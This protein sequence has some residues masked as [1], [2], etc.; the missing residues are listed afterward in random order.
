M[1]QEADW[2]TKTQEVS[3][4]VM[5]DLLRAVRSPRLPRTRVWRDLG[6]W[7]R[8]PQQVQARFVPLIGPRVHRIHGP[9]GTADIEFRLYL[10]EEYTDR[11]QISGSFTRGR[12]AEMEVHADVWQFNADKVRPG[13]VYHFRFLDKASGRWK[14]LTD[15]MA[16]AYTRRYDARSNQFDQFAIVPDLACDQRSPRPHPNRA[17]S[18]MECTL[19]G[20][21][22]KW[23][24]GAYAP[25]SGSAVSLAERVRSSGLISFLRKRGF[26]AVMFPMQA[27]VADLV[28][29]DWTFSYL[30]KGLGTIDTQIGSWSEFKELVDLFHHEGILVIPDLVLAHVAKAVS[31]RAPDQVGDERAGF[32]WFDKDAHHHRDFKTW[33]LRL[34]DPLIRQQ[35][36]DVVLRFVVELNLAAFRFDYVDGVM[37]QYSKRERNYGELLVRELKAALRQEARHVLCISEAFSTGSAPAVLDLADVVYQPWIGFDTLEELVTSR[38]TGERIDMSRIVMGLNEATGERQPRP[39][40]GFVLSHD[41]A[42]VNEMVMQERLNRHGRT[43]AAGGHLAQLIL[44]AADRLLQAKVLPPRLLLDYVANQ[45]AL[46][47]ATTMFGADFAYMNLGGFSDFLKLGAYGDENGWQTVWSVEQSDDLVHWVKLT[48]LSFDVVAKRIAEHAEQM[49]RLR[50]LYLEHTPIDFASRRALVDIA[51]VHHDP[52]RATL[53][54]VRRNRSERGRALLLAFNYGDALVE[55]YTFD[56]PVDLEGVW[57]PIHRLPAGGLA[58]RGLSEPKVDLTHPQKVRCHL[59]GNTLV[60]LERNR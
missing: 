22:A 4:A 23:C 25:R 38:M 45:A 24:G 7:F 2:K 28:Q 43:V 30:L 27:S 5:G 57:R 56:L 40:L 31:L 41:E 20:L 47:E 46:V 11:V 55:G 33:M 12:W 21:I 51:C 48:G 19:P 54:M 18:I 10:P 49:C 58:H 60:I 36:V 3:R 17:L 8:P 35:I 32:L 52:V 29:Y 34:D 14:S 39:G 59:P 42:S 26:N 37:L 53:G 15:P 1:R 16:Y 9:T 50:N 44:N 13:T 6:R